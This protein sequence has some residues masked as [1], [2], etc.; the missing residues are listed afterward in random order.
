[1]AELDSF[2]LVDPIDDR[3][4]L[5]VT[6]PPNFLVAFY[7]P[8]AVLSLIYVFGLRL[9]LMFAQDC[10][11]GLI[12]GGMTCCEVE[13]LPRCSWFAAPELVDEC[14][15]GHARD[16]RSNHVCIQDVRKLIALLREVADV[17]V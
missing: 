13:Q 8:I 10:T 6:V 1:M 9:T 17:L 4:E 12:I 7:S 5:A 11:Y 16:E 2:L 15:I 3:D 14:F